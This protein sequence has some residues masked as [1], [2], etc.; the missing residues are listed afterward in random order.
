MAT[1]LV[2]GGGGITGIAWQIGLLKGLRDLGVDLTAADLVVGT[3]AGAVVG[4]QLTSDVDLDELYAEQC[5]PADAEIG[6][7]YG[8]RQMLGLAVRLVLPATGRGRRRRLGRAARRAHPE[9]ATERLRVIGTRLRT[10]SGEPMD[11]PERDLR[12]TAIDADSGSFTVFARDSGVDL[13]HAVAAS[14]AVPLVWPAVEIDGRYYID[15]G[16][17]S[18]ANAD[19]AAG[20]RSVVAIAP[21][22]RTFTR[23]HALPAQLERTGA[24]HTTYVAPDAQALQAIGRNVLDPANRVGAARAGRAQAASVAE[25]VGAVWQPTG[26]GARESATPTADRRTGPS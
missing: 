3:S 22:T 4:A 5:R 19:L 1:G 13:L 8:P 6:G 21:L 14:C 18:A 23:Y 26:A 16:M 17:R 25:R 9:P 20:C 2:L 12:I 11:W 7:H 24:E 15:G 10:P